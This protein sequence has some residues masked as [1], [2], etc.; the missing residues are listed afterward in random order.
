MASGNTLLR[1]K[2]DGTFE[3]TTWKASANPVGWFWGASFGDFN[4]NGWQDI[5]AA[6]GWVYNDP[7]IGDGAG[8]SQQ[9][10]HPAE[11]AQ[12]RPIFRS[13]AFRQAFLAWV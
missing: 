3:D 6:D 5:Y 9:R 2:G 12:D 10:C 11:R 7:G 8:I 4:N 13:G 1:N